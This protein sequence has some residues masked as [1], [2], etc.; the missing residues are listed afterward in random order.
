MSLPDLHAIT[1]DYQRFRLVSLRTWSGAA[2]FAPVFAVCV[3]DSD[4]DGR[5]DVFLSQNFFANEAD[6]GRYAAG[7]GLWL[8]GDG[9]GGF[10]AMPGQHSGVLVYG[11]QRG[12]GLADFDGDGRVDLVVSQNGGQTKLY[13]NTAGKA[14]LRV[15]LVGEGGNGSGLGAVMRLGHEGHWGPAREVHGGAGYWSQDSAVQVLGKPGGQGEIQVR[16][17]SGKAILG[18]I[19]AEAKEIAVSAGGTIRQLR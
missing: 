16:W 1:N 9:L 12:A 14:G 13:R 15:R 4:G 5:E 18:P 11:E 8:R 3:G 19:P 6:A 10:T 2:Q 17:P 7:R